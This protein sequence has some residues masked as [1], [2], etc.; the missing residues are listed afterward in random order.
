MKLSKMQITKVLIS[1]RGCAGWSATLLFA[2]PEDRFSRIEAQILVFITLASSG[3]SD[4]PFVYTVSPEP[5]LLAYTKY[6]VEEDS[7]QK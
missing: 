7:D 2:N 1:L 5:L 3:A 6:G 4:K